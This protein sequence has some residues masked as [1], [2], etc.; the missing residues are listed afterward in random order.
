MSPPC[1]P[2]ELSAKC[3]VHGSAESALACCHTEL[4]GFLI[5]QVGDRDLAADLTQESCLRVLVA[6]RQGQVIRNPRALLYR[7]AR[8]LVIDHFRRRAVRR[9]EALDGVP[10]AMHPPAPGHLQPE[11]V[12]ASRETLQAYLMTIRAL[13]NRCREAFVLHI[14]AELPHSRIAHH[15]GIS[16]SM[17]EKHIARAMVACRRCQGRLQAPALRPQRELKTRP[18]SALKALAGSRLPDN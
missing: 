18:P 11:A 17:V 13:P 7:T 6:Q 10:E 1:F 5:R 15:M 16:L 8:N 9:H 14:F 3:P 4:L 12:L 2:D